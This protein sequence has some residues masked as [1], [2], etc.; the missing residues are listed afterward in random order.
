M[1]AKIVLIGDI[2]MLKM[3]LL[4]VVFI[5]S[6]F[7]TLIITS[8]CNFQWAAHGADARPRAQAVRPWLEAQAD[9]AGEEAAP[10]QKGGAA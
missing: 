3:N 1:N 5:L 10:R 9:G 2:L 7:E 8:K 4:G 6:V